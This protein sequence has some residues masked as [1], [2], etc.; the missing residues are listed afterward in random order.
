[1]TKGA[2]RSKRIQAK[3]ALARKYEN[4]AMV[5]RSTPRRRRLLNRVDR[6]LRQA[7]QLGRE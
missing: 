2:Q 5:A 3:L 1:M 6:Y 7:E 4:L